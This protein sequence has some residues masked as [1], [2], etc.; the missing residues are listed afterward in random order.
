MVI[1]MIGA[2]ALLLLSLSLLF[3]LGNHHRQLGAKVLVDVMREL[4]ATSRWNM[5]GKASIIH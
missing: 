3:L 5:D 4:R 1:V 2:A